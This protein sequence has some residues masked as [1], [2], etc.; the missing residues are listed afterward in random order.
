MM[1]AMNKSNEHVLAG[2]ACFNEK[3]DSHLVCVQNDDGN[4]QTQAISIHNQPRKVTGASF[5]VFSGALKSSS[6]YLAK[7]SI[8]EDGVM[9]Q[10][11]AENMDALRQ[12]LRDMK[13]FT[14]TCGK[15]DTED[16]Q[17]HIYIQWVDD[18][19]NVNKG[20]VSPIDGKS[21]ESI[22]S[23]KI[24]HGSEY[25]ANGKVIRWTEVF[26]LENDDQH[27]CLSDPADHSRLTEHVA[28]AF[29]LALCPHLKLL[30]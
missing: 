8:V 12:A 6:G 19:K 27:N 7:S 1:K 30:K 15:A 23:V 25:K 10:I 11:T 4:Y 20:V 29:C 16:P 14:I 21:M 28:K 26:F 13:D 2:G 3:A 5:F 22:T 18:D 17:E 9:V 24:F